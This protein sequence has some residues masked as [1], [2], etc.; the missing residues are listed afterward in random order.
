VTAQPQYLGEVD[1]AASH[2]LHMLVLLCDCERT[3][4]MRLALVRGAEV[5]EH[6]AEGRERV[7]LL[8]LCARRAR[9]SDRLLAPVPRLEPADEQ[10]QDETLA[11]EHASAQRGG[12]QRE[13]PRCLVERR[14]RRGQVPEP[15]APDALP[16]PRPPHRVAVGAQHR[17]R[18]P[19]EVHSPVEVAV[20]A[21]GLGGPAEQIDVLGRRRVVPELERA[22]EV[23]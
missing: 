20:G 14:F 4:Q 11:A 1:A 19:A 23:Q 17:Q 22:L 9:D 2:V 12:L 15:V 18:R 16:E 5:T 6:E 10:P 3:P 13:Q 7:S 8:E 21:R